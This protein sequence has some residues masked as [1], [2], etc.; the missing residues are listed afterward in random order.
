MPRQEQSDGLGRGQ[1]K[2]Y[3][4]GDEPASQRGVVTATMGSRSRTRISTRY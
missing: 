3:T 2:G 4:A 1:L